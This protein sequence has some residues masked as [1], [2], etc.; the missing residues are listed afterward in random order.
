M[1][2]RQIT[3]AYNEAKIYK[4][5]YRPSFNPLRLLRSVLTV[6]L[7]GNGATAQQHIP[8]KKKGL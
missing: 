5:Y 7:T 1:K 8:G 2:N 3:H 6:L 4:D